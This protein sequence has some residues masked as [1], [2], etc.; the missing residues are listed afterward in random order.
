MLTK[1][2]LAAA[3]AVA[4]AGVA[5]ASNENNGGNETGGYREFGPGGVASGGVNP[6]YHRSL[7]AHASSTRTRADDAYGFAPAR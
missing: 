1:L 3:L 4:T 2:A 7:R 6:A 5:L